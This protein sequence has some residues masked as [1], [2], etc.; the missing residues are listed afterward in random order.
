[1]GRERNA[2]LKGARRPPQRETPRWEPQR[3]YRWW[4][5]RDSPPPPG[6]TGAHRRSTRRR[7]IPDRSVPSFVHQ[8]ASAVC[9]KNEL[10]AMN[11]LGC[12]CDRAGLFVG[13]ASP[14]APTGRARRVFHVVAIWRERERGIRLRGRMLRRGVQ[15]PS[16]LV[17]QSA[18]LPTRSGGIRIR[19]PPQF[20]EE[21]V[22]W[23]SGLSFTKIVTHTHPVRRRY[24]A[25]RL[26]L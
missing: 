10:P 15:R 2:P 9:R 4:L 12:A 5:Q 23:N 25:W 22:P 26:F 7:R 3:P 19:L 21:A 20:R 24:A 8:E 16:M 18:K 11:E 13:R 1:M 14:L 6:R 17:A